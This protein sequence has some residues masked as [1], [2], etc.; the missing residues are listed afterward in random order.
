MKSVRIISLRQDRKR[1]L[2]HLQNSALI[3]IEKTEKSEKGFNKVDM[4]SQMQVFERNVALTQQT[5]QIL[6][7]LSPEKR[8]FYLLLKDEERLTPMKSELSPQ[9]RAK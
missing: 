6:D 3:Q 2:E 9:T 4:T 8:E 7:R 5:L 1:L